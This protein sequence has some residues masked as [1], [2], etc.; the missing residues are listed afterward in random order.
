MGSILGRGPSSIWVLLR[1]QPQQKHGGEN[2]TSLAAGRYRSRA[3]RMWIFAASSSFYIVMNW[4]SS[5]LCC[6]LHNRKD[7]T[8]CMKMPP[9]KW[10]W[11]SVKS[12]T[13]IEKNADHVLLVYSFVGP[14]A[15]NK[16]TFSLQSREEQFQTPE[17]ENASE[18]INWLSQQL[19]L[20][21]PTERLIYRLFVAAL[22]RHFPLCHPLIPSSVLSNLSPRLTLIFGPAALP[23]KLQQRN[24]YFLCRRRAEPSVH[25]PPLPPRGTHHFLMVQRRLQF[26]LA[27]KKKKK[28]S[29]VMSFCDS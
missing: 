10:W 20:F 16:K 7:V 17:P 25:P 5:S 21:L 6:R 24:R 11:W 27:Q 28:K 23:G 4:T 12:L 1:N 14:A 18:T 29:S 9:P 3:C 15:P 8:L 19:I 13:N 22:N 26:A 2:I